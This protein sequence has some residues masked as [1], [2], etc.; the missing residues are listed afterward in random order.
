MQSALS[1]RESYIALS[2]DS[3]SSIAFLTLSEYGG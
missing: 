1:R 3:R 2:N